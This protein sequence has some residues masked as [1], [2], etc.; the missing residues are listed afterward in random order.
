[1]M[2]VCVLCSNLQN[3]DNFYL[4]KKRAGGFA[5]SIV[6][7]LIGTLSLFLPSIVANT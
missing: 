7:R 4:I 6:G 5:S 1:M 2:T 3:V